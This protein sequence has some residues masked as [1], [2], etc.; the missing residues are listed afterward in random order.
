MRT[1][2]VYATLIVAARDRAAR[3]DG[4]RPGRVLRSRSRCPTRWRSLASM[5]VALTLTPALSLLLFA[6]P[7]AGGGPAAS[8]RATRAAASRRALARLVRRPGRRSSPRAPRGRGP[9][10]IPFAR[11]A[12]VPSFKDRDV[13]SAS[14]REPGTSLPR[15]DRDRGAREP[16]AA[17]R[18]RRRQRRRHVGRAVAGDAGGRR[19]R[20]S[21]G[22]HRPGRRLRPNA[23][24]RATRGPRRRPR[25]RRRLREQRSATSARCRR[26]RTR[27][28]QPRRADRQPTSRIV[29]RVYGQDPAI[30]RREAE[31]VRGSSRGSTASST[32]Q[33]ERRVTQ[34]SVEIEVDLARGAALRGQARRRASRGGDAAAGH[35]GRQHLPG[36]EGLR[37]RRAGRA[38]TRGER[39]R[40]PRPAHRPPGRRPRAPRRRRRRARSSDPGRDRARRR[41]AARR[42]QRGRRGRS[43]GRRAGRRR[44]SAWRGTAFPL[45]YHAEVVPDLLRRGRP[46]RLP[47]SR[48]PRDRRLPAPAGGVR[49]WRLAAL[50]FLALPVA[51]S[52]AVVA[53][54]D[55]GELSL[56]T[57]SGCS[58]STGCPSARW[59]WCAFQRL[60]L[61]GAD[62][63]LAWSS[64]GRRT[65][66]RRSSPPRRDGAGDAPVRD[67]R[68][69]GGPRDRASHGPRRPRRAPDVDTGQPVCGPR[70]SICAS[71]AACRRSRRRRS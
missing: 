70:R 40:R 25:S 49:S 26:R 9:R 60:E 3:G 58:R 11:H 10:A 31:R 38:G 20:A 6:R 50:A 4:G 1:P 34:P 27:R 65:G 48:S 43:A 39:Q 32:P 37:R 42:R 61:E 66:S 8:W 18:P 22:Q 52:A 7:P 24:D 55:G 28:A 30:L 67:R 63:G 36:P 59:S 19:T 21:L 33:A 35:P 15:D 44:G 23:A 56:G 17:R 68:Q 2:L 41:L 16:R 71:A 46:A 53:L 51:L 12:L 64:A 5:L 57:L 47:C 54:L 62:F 29:V 13:S 45:E 14:R 69:P